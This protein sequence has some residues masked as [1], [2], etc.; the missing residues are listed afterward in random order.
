MYYFIPCFD[1]KMMSRRM[2]Y[3]FS[4]VSTAMM[5]QFVGYGGGCGGQWQET[6]IPDVFPQKTIPQTARQQYC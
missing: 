6:E 1:K 3:F 5:A 4:N 2:L